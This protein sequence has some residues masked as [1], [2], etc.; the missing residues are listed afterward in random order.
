M[1]TSGRT[2][3][4]AAL[5]A[6]PT[7]LAAQRPP[8]VADEL[9]YLRRHGPVVVLT[10]PGVG[11]IVVVSPQYQGRVMTSGLSHDGPSIGWVNRAFI[12]AGTRGTPFDNYG[13]EDRFWL[14][15]EAGQFGLYFPPG[16]PFELAAW[17]VPAALNEGAW[18]VTARS[19]TSVTLT[20]PMRARNYAGTEFELRVDRTIRLLTAHDAADVA[21]TLPSGVRWVGYETINRVTNTGRAAWT[22]AG[23]LPSVWILGMYNTFGTS[24]VVVPVREGGAGAVNDRYF[25]KVPAERLRAAGGALLFTGDGRFRSKIGVG[26]RHARPVLGSWAPAEGLLTLVRFD[27]PADA[28]SRPYVNSMWERQ[29]DP[30]AG[31]VVNAYND[32]PPNPG[33]FYELESS[34]PALALAP[35]ASHTHRHRTLHLTGPAAALDAVARRALGTPVS[36]LGARR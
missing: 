29:R 7:L 1:R 13:G 16:K 5:A 12:D 14:G 6:A 34:S 18:A 24:H 21:G 23:G 26:P 32:G 30:F 36:T 31:D 25:G 4:G 10:P 3:L 19:D 20:R 33:G 22:R 17:Q 11:T 15:P 28:A 35:G 8:T 9:A 27:L 2:L